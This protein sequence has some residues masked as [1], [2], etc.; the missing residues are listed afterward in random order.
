MLKTLLLQNL[1][2]LEILGPRLPTKTDMLVELAELLDMSTNSLLSSCMSTILPAICDKGGVAEIKAL[3]RQ[4]SMTPKQ[5]L[6]RYGQYPLTASF[7]TETPSMKKLLEIFSS[8]MEDDFDAFA[9]AITARTLLELVL[10]TGAH[11]SWNSCQGML[12]DSLVDRASKSIGLLIIKLRDIDNDS[13]DDIA[14]L[15]A[16]GDHVT[17]LLKHLGDM[18]DDMVAQGGEMQSNSFQSPLKIVRGVIFLIKVTGK[19]VGR[20]LPQFL[21]LLSAS[22]RTSIPADVRV[23]GLIGWAYLIKS[24][25]SFAPLQLG[26]SSNQIVV[27]L[28]DC[29]Q[30]DGSVG[31]AALKALEVLI[32]ACKRMFP[33]KLHSLPPIPQCSP[34][35]KALSDSLNLTQKSSINEKVRSLLDGLKDEALNVRVVT[36]RELQNIFCTQRHWL[37]TLTNPSNA[38]E[39]D[40]LLKDLISALIKSSDPEITSISSITAQQLCAECLGM[41]GALDPSRVHINTT[42]EAS[43]YRDLIDLASNIMTNHLI[44]L[45]MTAH[46]MSVLDRIT[47]AI[48]DVLRCDAFNEKWGQIG[49]KGDSSNSAGSRNVFFDILPEEVQAL[50]RPYL[51]S[52]YTF[53]PKVNIERYVYEN[54][55]RLRTWIGLWLV[56]MINS[57]GET[58]EVSFFRATASVVMFDVPT[59]MALAPYIVLAHLEHARNKAREDIVGEI[60][61]V[62]EQNQVPTKDGISCMQSIFSLLDVLRLWLQ[63]G[64]VALSQSSAVKGNEILVGFDWKLLEDMI[65]DIP[66]IKL[67]KAASKCGA[68]ARALLYYET[69]LRLSGGKGANIAAASSTKFSDDEVTFLLGLYSKLEE[70]DALG[71]VMKLRQGTSTLEDQRLAAE[72]NGSWGEASSLYELEISSKPPLMD[73]RLELMDGYFNCLLQMGHWEGLAGQ[74]RGLL[75]SKDSKPTL[76]RS[77]MASKGAAALWRL[78]KFDGEIKDY[79]KMSGPIMDQLALD[80]KWELRVSKLLC[81]LSEISHSVDERLYDK[82]SKELSSMRHEIMPQFSAAAKESYAR[83]YPHLV[84]LHMIQEISDATGALR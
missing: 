36:L 45:L 28:L 40:N 49:R 5:L 8:V 24:L 53:T 26:S 19:Y 10:Q 6:L 18:F 2:L 14:P 34:E 64:K 9:S 77:K 39:D 60:L 11:S 33:E 52:K 38:S 35:L 30:E 47:V 76:E 70:P 84:K 29:L 31:T 74:V 63:D 42:F 13:M 44:K 27:A 7:M 21:V 25:A 20:F 50:V 46:S 81:Y 78:G 15:L 61:H 4:V 69:H 68:H 65:E 66:R 57:S 71:G 83:A 67:A 58:R 82:V 12:P 62:I 79:I 54:N 72:K 80:E 56:K 32:D 73:S 55:M 51:D 22:I 75:L 1:P 41:L 59:A 37:G 17:R 48:Q 43:R 3:S 16:D 23:Q